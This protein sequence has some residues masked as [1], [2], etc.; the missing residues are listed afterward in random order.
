MTKITVTGSP[1]S[2]IDKSEP[3]KGAS[4]VTQTLCLNIQ[5]LGRD[6]PFSKKWFEVSVQLPETFSAL[7]MKP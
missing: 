7:R 1:S 5:T 2:K 6:L 3:M 4:A